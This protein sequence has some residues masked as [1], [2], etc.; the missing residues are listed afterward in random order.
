MESL[1]KLAEKVIEW[2][3]SSPTYVTHHM[4]DVVSNGVIQLVNGAKTLRPNERLGTLDEVFN[5]ITV[6]AGFIDVFPSIYK[7]VMTFIEPGALDMDGFMW[8]RTGHD[9]P[10][11]ARNTNFGL[12]VE[13]I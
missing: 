13:G 2:V 11:T 12:G 5:T 4:N 9:Y 8:G 10:I 7:D 1:L 3:T 6:Y